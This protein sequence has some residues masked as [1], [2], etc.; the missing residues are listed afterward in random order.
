MTGD[1]KK[2]KGK[3]NEKKPMLELDINKKLEILKHLKQENNS[4]SPRLPG[5]QRTTTPNTESNS[6]SSE[7]KTRVF[8]VGSTLDNFKKLIE[9]N[10]GLIDDEK[11][12]IKTMLLPL[13]K[14]TETRLK[15]EKFNDFVKEH[16]YDI[17]ARLSNQLENK[18]SKNKNTPTTPYRKGG[19]KTK[20]TKKGRNKQKRNIIKT[21]K[22]RTTKGGT[23]PRTEE[24]NIIQMEEGNEIIIKLLKTQEKIDKI[25]SD[26]DSIRIPT[27]NDVSELQQNIASTIHDIESNGAAH[28]YHTIL[29]EGLNRFININYLDEI[30]ENDEIGTVTSDFET[31][32]LDTVMDGL[33]AEEIRT[34][35]FR[36][37]KFIYRLIIYSCIFLNI[38]IFLHI[39]F[40]IFPEYINNINELDGVDPQ[41]ITFSLILS[42]F[43]FFSDIIAIIYITLN[44][45]ILINIQRRKITDK[46]IAH[47]NEHG[48]GEIDSILPDIPFNHI[49]GLNSNHNVK[50]KYKW[51]W[52]KLIAAKERLLQETEQPPQTNTQ[53]PG[54]DPLDIIVSD[55]AHIT[56]P[57]DTITTSLNNITYWLGSI[58][59]HNAAV[60]P[61]N[62]ADVPETE[63]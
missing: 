26:S 19:K 44:R 17:L 2:K 58:L 38:I 43:V 18:Y 57:P 33:L 39:L 25:I 34:I 60:V 54:V 61:V 56:I 36:K 13:I 31:P 55:P 53:N 10:V 32:T 62:P 50:K 24:E 49:I 21:L 52:K 40:T 7:K 8:N 35:I 63:T 28:S 16:F 1:S 14:T 27:Q 42:V 23:T 6:N 47:L 37:C 48:Y 45:G 4:K 12:T 20:K 59:Q 41:I 30:I 15:N 11:G 5:K 9:S 22:K 51:I 3:N 46:F 29:R